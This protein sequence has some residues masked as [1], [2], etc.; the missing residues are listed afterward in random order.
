MQ[1]LSLGP[2]VGLVVASAL[3][4][5]S[6]RVA[7]DHRV[8][9]LA[10]VFKLAGA[11]EYNQNRFAPYIA[12]VQAYFSPHKQHA[13]IERVR[14]VRQSNGLT[15]DAV[16]SV[17]VH[18][19]DPPELRPLVPFESGRS[20]WRAPAVASL[21]D[22]LR[23]FTVETRA[24]EFF[25]SH[26]TLYDS[27]G[28]RLGRLVR[29]ELDAEW[30]GKFFGAASDRDFTV[31]P[32]LANS[33]TNFGPCA[34]PDGGRQVCYAIIGHVGNDSAGF[35]TYGRDVVS[36]IVHEF[37]H[38]YANPVMEARIADFERAA[39][40]VLP[41]VA[42]AM[43]EQGYTQT[44]SMLNETLVRAVVARYLLD[45]QGSEVEQAYLD[46]ERAKGWLWVPEI[47]QRLGDYTAHRQQYPTL[48]SFMPRVASYFDSLPA[49]LSDM[50][51]RYDATR[52]VVV[53][54]SIENGAESIDPALAKIEIRFDQRMR[55]GPGDLRPVGPRER[56][57]EITSRGFDSAQTVFTLAVKLEPERE[58][59]FVLNRASGGRFTSGSGVP[60][61]PYRIRFKTR[62]RPTPGP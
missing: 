31:V 47:A 22:E 17:A 34:Q 26:R 56:M 9:L 35:P 62:A 48:L 51:T 57:P 59:D 21:I 16:M 30:F 10:I 52:P 40:L 45:R 32:L 12:D 27:A 46:E 28:T 8:E 20:R 37:T 25:T 1:R 24:V 14:A 38:G 4:A 36:T 7:V 49:R 15:F 58:Y 39:G 19:S 5:Q 55:P 33:S 42:D 60:L 18:V 23:R 54:L 61:A 11:P 13:A 2:I 3:P 53:S 43:G 41:T 29:E 50:H 44:R 6:P